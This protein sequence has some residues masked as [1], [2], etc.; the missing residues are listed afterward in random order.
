MQLFKQS[1]KWLWS[2]DSLH[3]SLLCHWGIDHTHVFTVNVI[4]KRECSR[5]SPSV[6][7]KAVFFCIHVQITRMKELESNS[8]W[9][10]RFS[11]DD[12]AKG[13][14]RID[15]CEQVSCYQQ[16]RLLK[17]SGLIFRYFC[18][19]CLS[20]VDSVYRKAGNYRI[21]LLSLSI[22]SFQLLSWVVVEWVAGFGFLVSSSH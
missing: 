14:V 6:Q 22:S 8:S 17:N 13:G 2:Y 5:F 9:F 21:L 1:S 15:F 12:E 3:F 7:C 19:C 10:A 11:F 20:F 4:L 16:R 18:C